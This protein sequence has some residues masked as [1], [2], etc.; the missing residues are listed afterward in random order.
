M[1]LITCP[2]CKNFVSDQARTC[3]RCGYPIKKPEYRSQL[4]TNRDGIEKGREQLNKLLSEGW[5]IVNTVHEV[6]SSAYDGDSWDVVEYTL[7]R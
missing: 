1:A 7:R 3:P 6:E 2:E 4:I 5:E